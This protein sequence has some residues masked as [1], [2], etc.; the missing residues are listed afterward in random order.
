M[1]I[2]N[3]IEYMLASAFFFLIFFQKK[4]NL[5]LP[6]SAL[7]GREGGDNGGLNGGWGGVKEGEAIY[8]HQALEHVH[9]VH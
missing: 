2:F 5:N 9:L 4:K 8:R 1:L 7:S 6:H 3:F